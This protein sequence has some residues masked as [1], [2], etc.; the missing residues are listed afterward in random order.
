VEVVGVGAE[1]ARQ[2]QELLKQVLHVSLN[3][4]GEDK[5]EL[6][7][8]SKGIAQTITRGVRLAEKLKGKEWLDPK[9]Q[10]EMIAENEMMKAAESIEKAAQR[11]AELKLKR[12]IISNIDTEVQSH[13]WDKSARMG[14]IPNL[15]H[16][17]Q[18]FKPSVCPIWFR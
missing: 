14:K 2:F 11:L 12:D 9:E 8:V 15:C 4:A 18:L 5:T 6:M 1:L 3:P 7:A 17:S 10:M 16:F 13:I